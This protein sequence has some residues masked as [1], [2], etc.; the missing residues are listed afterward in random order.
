[1]T[2]ILNESQP[3][4]LEEAIITGKELTAEEC[5][6]LEE[7]WVLISDH[8]NDVQL[9]F[10]FTAMNQRKPDFNVTLVFS[11]VADGEKDGCY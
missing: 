11:R 2:M 9:I 1:M 6:Y 10:N 3:A 8:M 4:R 5:K 7:L